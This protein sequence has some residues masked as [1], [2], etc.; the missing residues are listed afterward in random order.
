VDPGLDGP[1]PTRAQPARWARFG[2]AGGDGQAGVR[3]RPPSPCP[4]PAGGRGNLGA[5]PRSFSPEGE[6]V[7]MRGARGLAR[8]LNTNS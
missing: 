3:S 2:R 1:Q 4:S 8:Q 5:T 7:R 6:K